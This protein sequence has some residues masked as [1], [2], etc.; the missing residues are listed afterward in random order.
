MCVVWS[1][2]TS[3]PVFRPPTQTTT[4]PHTPP[5]S[6]PPKRYDDGI[7]D[8]VNT[9]FCASVI[10]AQL[11]AHA[12]PRPR[13]RWRVADITALDATT[14]PDASFD[15]VL[16]KGGL[17][18]LHSDADDDGG[19]GDAA[20]QA[21]LAC[22]A[23]VTARGGS[24]VCVTLAQPHVLA[25]ALAVFRTRDW[26]ITLDAP[27]PP[28]DMAAAPLQPLVV[29]ATRRNVGGG[30]N[31]TPLPPVVS[32]INHTLTA[33]NADQ[34]DGVAGVVA[35]E[36]EARARGERVGAGPP[37]CAPPASPTDGDPFASL[38]PG[39]TTRLTLPEG[40]A[41]PCYDVFIVDASSPPPGPPTAAVFV[42][43][44]GRDHEWLFA[45][46]EGVATVAAQVGAGR[47]IIVRLCRGADHGSLAAVRSALS[48]HVAPL[49]PSALRGVAGA[50]PIVTVGEGIGSRTRVATLASQVAGC[51]VLI[52]D[53]SPPPDAPK[54]VVGLRRLV[55]GG[56]VGLVQSEAVLVKEEVPGPR[57]SGRG[58]G[59]AGTRA[60]PPPSPKPVVAL[61]DHLPAAYHSAVLAHLAL[62]G[63]CVQGGGGGRGGADATTKPCVAVIGLGGGGLP[64]ALTAHAGLAVTTVELDPIVVDVAR[65]HFGFGGNVVTGDGAAFIAASRPASLA[66]IIVDA[67]GGDGAGAM[68]CPPPAFA[69]REFV[70]AARAALTGNGVL[71]INVVAR[72]TA[73][74][75]ALIDTLKAEFECVLEIDVPDDVNRVLAATQVAVDPAP[76]AAV[77]ARLHR[78]LREAG[79]VVGGASVADL[80]ELV[81]AR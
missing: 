15:L 56:A 60:A 42:V 7:T 20:A 45:L 27:P 13:M 41:T 28:L 1:R 58:G 68:A 11:A 48:P 40:A 71:I 24:Y 25:C 52:E 66:A 31:A 74:V 10:R 65:T 16:D 36:N 33:P 17:D 54:G 50:V 8:I 47:V 59:R 4:D 69:R 64:A 73:P 23:R 49:T 53:V 77:A 34:L 38:A 81:V 3:F 63:V 39:R 5:P 75:A 29:V 57:R 62:A 19:G 35:A 37:A 14:F 44:L 67:G 72:S 80:A 76:G 22:A 43:P 26:T 51:N 32:R 78:A 79:G 70:S 9:D 46:E 6:H 30:D 2:L 21:M 12:R 55:F 18:A 61:A